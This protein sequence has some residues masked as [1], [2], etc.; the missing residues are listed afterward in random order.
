MRTP[1]IVSCKII[2]TMKKEEIN[3]LAREVI[4][5][6]IYCTK[7][8][9]TT[10]EA[11]AYMGISKSYLHKLTMR[12]EIPFYKPMGKMCYFDRNELED[13]ITCNRASTNEEL[14]QRAQT[15]CMKK[16]GAI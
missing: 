16:G 8:I 10:D 9:L 13:W 7:K 5:G 4:E 6:T 3:E 15:Y 14:N 12:R 2:P 1:S 11:A